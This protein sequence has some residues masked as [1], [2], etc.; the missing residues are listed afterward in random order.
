MSGPVTE[1]AP[2]WPWAAKDVGS[3]WYVVDG[4]GRVIATIYPSV[5]RAQRIAELFAASPELLDAARRAYEQDE[6]RE[7]EEALRETEAP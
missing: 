7:L 4:N 5:P 2:P 1:H 3:I 6:P